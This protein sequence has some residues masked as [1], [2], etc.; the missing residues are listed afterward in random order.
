[1]ISDSRLVS[2][3]NRGVSSAALSTTAPHR[4]MVSLGRKMAP[5]TRLSIQPRRAEMTFLGV[6]PSPNIRP[7]GKNMSMMTAAETKPK[8][9]V[10]PSCTAAL[11]SVSAISAKAMAVV[12]APT[13]TPRPARPKVVTRACSGLC[14]WAR[15]SL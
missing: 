15:S 1:M 9:A 11:K 10:M 7:A 2:R 14:A 13:A 12:K 5:R 4:P 8:A 6:L 3:R